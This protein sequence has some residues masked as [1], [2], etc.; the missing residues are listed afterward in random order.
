MT[1]CQLYCFSRTVSI[2]CQYFRVLL[3][4]ARQPT[5][6]NAQ[7]RSCH[8]IGTIDFGVSCRYCLSVSASNTQSLYSYLLNDLGSIN[9][10]FFRQNIQ[11]SLTAFTCNDNFV[12]SKSC[13][14]D[15]GVAIVV[16]AAAAIHR[17]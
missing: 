5:A 2:R 9:G 6:R 7:L 11:V 10:W 17:C 13:Q 16:A 14:N 1:L 12:T 15:S 8:C 3:C 4:V